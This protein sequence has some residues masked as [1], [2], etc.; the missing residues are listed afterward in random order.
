MN[1]A[2]VLAVCVGITATGPATWCV[3]AEVKSEGVLFSEGFEDPDFAN[4]G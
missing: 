2:F 3:G 1:R 4:R